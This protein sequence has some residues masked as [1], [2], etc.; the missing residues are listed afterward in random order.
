[1]LQLNVFHLNIRNILIFNNLYIIHDNFEKKYS[2]KMCWILLQ[3]TDLL[4]DCFLIT[5]LC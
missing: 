5:R 4:T 2:G 3:E 1:M